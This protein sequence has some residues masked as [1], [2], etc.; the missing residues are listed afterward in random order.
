[1]TTQDDLPPAIAAWVRQLLDP[2][3]VAL[4]RGLQVE[5]IDVKLGAS[6]GKVNRQPTIILNGGPQEMVSA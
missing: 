3:F 6:K 1:M 4:V 2:Q 5:R